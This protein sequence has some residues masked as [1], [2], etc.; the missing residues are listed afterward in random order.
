MVP[1]RLDDDYRLCEVYEARLQD[2]QSD[3]YADMIAFAHTDGKYYFATTTP[4]GGL[5]MRS[6][7]YPNTGA[8]AVGMKSVN[9][10]RGQRT[11]YAVI[12]RGGKFFAVLRAQNGQEILR[13]CG[14]AS[15]DEAEALFPP[16][17][18]AAAA[19][20]EKTAVAEAEAAALAASAAAEIADEGAAP[21]ERLKRDD[22]YLVCSAYEAQLG[23]SRHPKHDNVVEFRHANDKYYFAV[24]DAE[25]G[26]A[27]RSEGYPTTGA[28][29]T[30]RKAV[31]RNLGKRNRYQVEER[32]GLF[33]T[34]LSAQNGQEI[35]RSCPQKDR[36]AAEALLPAAS[37][38][39][40]A[41]A[42][43]AEADARAR[44][45]EVEAQESQ[46]VPSTSPAAADI[47]GPQGGER[48]Q[49]NYLVCSAYEARLRDS[50]H[51]KHD[52]VI[53]FA[54][55][56]GLYYFAIVNEDGSLFLRS[57]G[58][59]NTGARD[60]GRKAVLRNLSKRNR[61]KVEEKR[62]LHYTVLY[63]QN[64]QEI[65]R[66]C[67]QKD[68]AV[69]EGLL[70]GLSAASLALAA[71]AEAP[72][73]APAPV[74]RSPEPVVDRDDDYLACG[75]YRNRFV[76]DPARR[77]AH[78]RHENGLYYFVFYGEG[79]RVRLRSEGFSD[80]DK[81]DSELA[82]A[83]RLI[84][85]EG[86]YERISRGGKYINV[87]RDETGR[88][89][90]RS[91]AEDE[92]AAFVPAGLAATGLA[93]AAAVGAAA[94]LGDDAMPT[95][96]PA[97]PE[98]AA[99]EP[100]REKEDDYLKCGEY[101]GRKIN[102]KQNRVALF[103][104]GNGQYYF[105]FYDR[106][107]RVRLR[108][109]GF[110]TAKGRDQELSGALRFIGDEAYWERITVGGRYINVLRDDTGRE[111]GRSCVSS[112]VVPFLLPAAAGAGAAALAG[113]AAVAAAPVVTPAPV[114]PT[115]AP[116]A[117][118]PPPA[119][120]P[121]V[122]EKGGVGWWVWALAGLAALALLL[123]LLRGCFGCGAVATGADETTAVTAAPAPVV[124]PVEPEPVEPAPVEAPAAVEPPAPPPPAPEP[125]TAPAPP[126]PPA[127]SAAAVASDGG[128]C[129][130]IAVGAPLSEEGVPLLTGGD[131]GGLAGDVQDFLAGGES[132]AS[133]P[134][135]GI[136]FESP[137]NDYAVE[138]CSIANVDR[139]AAVLRDN[140]NARITVSAATQRQ[141]ASL[142]RLLTYRGVDAGRVDIAPDGDARLIVTRG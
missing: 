129:G 111:V 123:F 93:G 110:R 11:R 141:C 127:T 25:G 4:D 36:G 3:E 53:E 32:R 30:G 125:V 75:E 107:N 106:D 39:S 5:E 46:A 87:L 37:A 134:L 7:G 91:C 31:L 66:S 80:E 64:G 81:R 130:P 16:L 33:Y 10:F 45:A 133:F 56:N 119:A 83:K 38:A 98:P 43:Q 34:V 54:H 114:S 113:A 139:L 82:A 136:A 131:Y 17:S 142:K 62:G 137:G 65:G 59:P 23:G 102:D 97:A 132:T 67:P 15:R 2:S 51:P 120:A 21:S 95:P 47:S 9:R 63:A 100:P 14:K 78:F 1:E 18:A 89:V 44:A 20:A 57:E 138:P 26:L 115:P 96:E 99:P 90:G 8:R 29:D 76:N 68:R 140:P 13:S 86:R 126:P 103:K 71:A 22:D 24:L 88:E 42:A 79:D 52:N 28:R 112:D 73:P 48:L 70:P 77:I 101:A 69:A 60:V 85:D 117:A 116:A 128:A 35:A 72:A 50:R 61:F 6:E 41:L 124:A 58:Y 55:D 108:S 109:E 12:E 49:D 118:A 84:D 92:P 104:H 135:S 105:A 121:V 94:M 19:L 74:S 27:L 40:L 122:A